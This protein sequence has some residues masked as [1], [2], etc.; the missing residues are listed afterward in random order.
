MRERS[1]K[2]AADGASADAEGAVVAR[3]VVVALGPWSDLVFRPLG[4]SIPLGVKRGY[5]LH[6]AASGNAVL[7]SSRARCRSTAFCWRR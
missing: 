6:L 2:P 7:Q 3:E 4:Y 1:N 5:H